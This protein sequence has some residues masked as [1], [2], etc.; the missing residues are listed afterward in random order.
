LLD[1]HGTV[2]ASGVGLHQTALYDMLL[3]LVLFTLLWTLNR[4]PRREGIL[5]LTFG[6]FYGLCRLLEDSLRIDKRLGP[7]TGSQ[8]TAMTVAIICA[9]MLL[10][11]AVHPGRGPAELQEPAEESQEPAEESQEPAGESQEPAE[12]PVR[13][14]GT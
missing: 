5:T 9:L 1:V 11:W 13:D 7:L 3:A 8:W 6:L 10:W 12:E 2:I 14:L 4:K